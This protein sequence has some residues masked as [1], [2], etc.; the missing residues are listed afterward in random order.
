MSEMTATICISDIPK[1][2]VRKGR[3]GKEYIDVF[4]GKRRKVS[5]YGRTHYIKIS[6]R[7]DKERMYDPVYIGDA[8]ERLIN[9]EG[10][11]SQIIDA[12]QK[13]NTNTKP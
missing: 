3:D 9:D 13:Q 10:N 4:I 11:L 2:F 8:T 7:V 5:P 12:L 1:Q 6:H